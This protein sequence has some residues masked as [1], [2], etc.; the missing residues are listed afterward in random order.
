MKSILITAPTERPLTVQE[1]KDFLRVDGNLEDLR[2]ETMI[3][4]ATK[5][6]E[7]YCD[8]KIITQVWDI[9]LDHFP[10]NRKNS[11]W[12][13]SKD[14]AFGEM[15]SHCPVVHLPFGRLISLDEFQTFAYDGTSTLHTVSDYDIDFV[16]YR[17]RISLKY[18]AVWPVTTL[19]LVNGIRFRVT[20][21]FGNAASVPR[22]LKQAVLEIVADMFEN[23]GDEEPTIPPRALILVAEYRKVKVG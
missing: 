9:F 14:G 19:R 23:R 16:D 4:A 17:G 1:A 15:F 6:L 13:G 7:S 11:W 10:I 8:I 21:G 5:L 22:N 12:D 20:V 3:D 18:G 2:I